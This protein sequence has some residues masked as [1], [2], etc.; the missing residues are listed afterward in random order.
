MVPRSVTEPCPCGRCPSQPKEARH[1][2]VSTAGDPWQGSVQPHMR[3]GGAWLRR[4][5]FAPK[6][7]Y[8]IQVLGNGRLLIQKLG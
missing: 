4:A 3:F 1:L 6:D 8:V 2:T 7:K 5:G